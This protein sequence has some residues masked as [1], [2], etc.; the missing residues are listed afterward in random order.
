MLQWFA[1]VYLVTSEQ[2]RN[3]TP[4]LSVLFVGVFHADDPKRWKPVKTVTGVNETH[5][6]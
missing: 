2:R 6:L 5:F 1:P 3:K 4:F